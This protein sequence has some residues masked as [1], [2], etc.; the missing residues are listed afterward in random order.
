VDT[1]TLLLIIALSEVRILLGQLFCPVFDENR[2]F[3]KKIGDSSSWIWEVKIG[4]PYRKNIM[5]K[6]NHYGFTKMKKS[7]TCDLNLLERWTRPAIIVNVL[8]KSP[9]MAPG[10]SNK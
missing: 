8:W 9:K 1:N 5:R 10:K 2:L 7:W 4:T 6:G 3:S